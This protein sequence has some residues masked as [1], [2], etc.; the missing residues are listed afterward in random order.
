MLNQENIRKN[1][2]QVYKKG[3]NRMYKNKTKKIVKKGKE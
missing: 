1:D 2:M 3:K